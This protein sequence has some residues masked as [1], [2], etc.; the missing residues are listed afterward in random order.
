MTDTSVQWLEKHRAKFET[1]KEAAKDLRISEQYYADTLNG[2][3]GMG[4]K[5]LTALGLKRVAKVVRA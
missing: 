5:I 2:K 3:R 4:P 1:L